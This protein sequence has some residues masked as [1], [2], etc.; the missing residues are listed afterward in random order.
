MISDK[1]L[2]PNK[3]IEFLLIILPI[4]LL[5]SNILSELLILLLIIFSAIFLKKEKFLFFF[6][7]PLI[8]ILIVFWIYL[9]FNYLINFNNNPSLERT[10]FF[11]RFPLLIISIS[12][13]INILNL[14][15]QKIFFYWG[16]IILVICIDLFFQY[17]MHFNLIGNKPIKHGAVFRLGG[18]MGDELKISNLINHFGV[19]VFSY[20]YSKYPNFNKQK[21]LNFIFLFLIISSIFITGE[22]SNFITIIFFTFLFIIFLAL[23][24][25]KIFIFFAIIFSLILGVLFTSNENLSERMVKKLVTKSTKIVEFNLNENFLK[26]DSHHF[27]HYSVAYQIFKKNM[28]FGSGLKTFRV[29]CDDDSFD[30]EIHPKWQSRK[31][32]TH[33]HN[34][35]FEVLSEIGIFGFLIL[36]IFFI[37]AFYEFFKLYRKTKNN[38]LIISSFILLVYFIPFLPKG[39]F[40]TNWNAMI[41]WTIFAFIYSNYIKLKK[42]NEF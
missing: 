22:R 19:L 24:D 32:S 37:F 13:F 2:V 28:A 21:L 9:I 8:I 23:T 18:F 36:I 20:F 16:L 41:F 38:Y 31:C 5:F 15:T 17:H 29:Y 26:K 33:P 30:K 25:K 4:S 39:S 12:F 3:I 11:V 1:L 27:A 7:E 42:P 35:Y 10:L 34:F 6:K 40:F 14:N